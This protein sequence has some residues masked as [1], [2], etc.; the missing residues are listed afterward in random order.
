MK[1]LIATQNAGK[2]RELE[3]ILA[4]LGVTL[5]TPEE[6]LEVPEA[7]E[8]G[9]TFEENALKKARHWFMATGLPTLADDS[10]LMVDALDGEPGVRSARYAPTVE[11]R[12]AKLLAALEGILPERRTARFVCVAVFIRG[13]GDEVIR[14]GTCEGR[15][16]SEPRGDG[17]FGYDP[18][19]WVE[20]HG[21]TMAELPAQVK[22]QIS[23]RARALAALQPDLIEWVKTSRRG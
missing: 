6:F 9:E 8:D 11:E 15:I 21:C 4:P 18:I 23:H 20:G 16:H 3:A 22:N 19:F 14:R 13:H 17:G 12:N 5:S 1:L 2:I 7:I 10:G